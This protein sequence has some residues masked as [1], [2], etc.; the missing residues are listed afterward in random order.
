[1]EFFILLL[2]FA[3]A[4]FGISLP[5]FQRLSQSRRNRKFTVRLGTSWNPRDPQQ[6]WDVLMS[7]ISFMVALAMAIYLFSLIFPFEQLDA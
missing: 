6:R 1:M 2:L 5:V 3:G 4:Y 7:F